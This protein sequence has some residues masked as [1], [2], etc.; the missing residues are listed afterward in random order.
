M[1]IAREMKNEKVREAADHATVRDY[2]DRFYYRDVASETAIPRH[3]R[4]LARR[5]AP[6][7]G[8]RLLDIGCG[9]GLWLRAATALG[10]IPAGIDI[11]RVAVDAC[12]KHLPGAELHC[13]PAE[14]LPFGD[15]QFDFVSCLGS[16]EHFLDPENALREMVRVAKPAAT[17]LLLVPNADFL[18]RRLGLYSGTH[19][20]AVR[21]EVRTLREWQDLF[22]SVGLKVN[23]RWKDLHILTLSWITR[24]AWFLWP[25][26]AAQAL[27][28]PLWPL[29]SQYQ[30][31][32]DCT[33]GRAVDE[34]CRT[35]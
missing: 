23:A 4:R 16:L 20:S 32:H 12:R 11:S 35:G 22:E 30:V 21:E 18:P 1:V 25:V 3:Y 17:L 8:R 10:A 19:Q 9:T 15:R 33:L 13:G 6:W 31:Y 34:A 27:L 5:F 28:L 29:S 14:R 24:G 26:R 7:N 2:Y